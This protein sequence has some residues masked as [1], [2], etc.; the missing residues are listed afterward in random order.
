M[1]T[2][3]LGE[4]ECLQWLSESV[5]HLLY[6]LDVDQSHGTDI[7][8]HFLVNDVS[9]TT[10]FLAQEMSYNDLQAEATSTV[11][12]ILQVMY[13]NSNNWPVS[14]D[15]QWVNGSEAW[16]SSSNRP[17]LH[18]ASHTVVYLNTVHHDVQSEVTHKMKQHNFADW[19]QITGLQLATINWNQIIFNMLSVI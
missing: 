19:L 5:Q 18:T 7:Y 15:K 13:Y 9:N 6:S 17:G 16:D 10:A 12:T 4:Q 1:D 11:C 14:T 8:S 3:V 2:I